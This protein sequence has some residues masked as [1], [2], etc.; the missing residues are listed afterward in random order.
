M[1]ARSV[2]IQLH[3]QDVQAAFNHLL[4]AN[5]DLG[6]AWRAIGEL[7]TESTKRRFE[8]STSPDGRR[9]APNSPITL[10]AM[11][12]Q[13]KGSFNKRDGKLSAKGAGLVMAKKPLLG[14][15]KALSTTI[16][17]RVVSDGVLIGSPM[18]YAAM[19]HFGG[20]KAEFP[21]LWGDIPARPIFG[22]S[23]EDNAGI[24]EI[25]QNHLL[26]QK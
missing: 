20:T 2:D 10:A 26:G 6:P 4:A 5:A 18:E 17:Y 3:D 11:L 21:N 19:Q 24:L 25:L 22:V 7:L 8:T 9:W 1:T 12:A 15:S 13:R 23:P 14:E 16:T